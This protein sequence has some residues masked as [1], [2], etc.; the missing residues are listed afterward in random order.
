M[1]VLMIHNHY[2]T[3]TPAGEDTVFRQERALLESGGTEVITFERNNDSVDE[4]DWR[5]VLRTATGM[6]WSR[7]VYDE[8]SALVQRTRPDVVHLHNTFPLISPSA[9]AACSDAGVAVVQT[10]HNFRHSC[11][12]ATFYRDGRVC[13]DCA[14]GAIW[15]GIAHRCY[16]GSLTGSAAVAH[17]LWLSRRGRYARNVTRYIALTRFAAAKLA[18]S[19]VAT[20][21]IVVKPNFYE[22]QLPPGSGDGGYILFCGRLS[23][24]KGVLSLLA[25]LRNLPGVEL[26]IVGEGPQ[27]AE[28]ENAAQGL[29][30]RMVGLVSRDEVFRL[31]G[32][33]ALVVVPSQWYEG[34]PLVIVEAFA[35]GTPVAAAEIGGLAEIVRSG[36]TG[37]KFRPGDADSIAGALRDALGDAARLRHMRATCRDEYESRYTADANLVQMRQIYQDA[38]ELKKAQCKDDAGAGRGG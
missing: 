22:T 27:R 8:V 9:A 13:E 4:R 36:E 24:E 12:P 20:D 18:A 16:R 15:R 7:S 17:S 28:I 30:V 11:L 38:I 33:A 2:R 14:G 34:F 29:P 6:S 3:G 32:E 10:V 1:R 19:G 31:M 25:A 37:V 26:R 35:A 23:A 5:Q 21:R